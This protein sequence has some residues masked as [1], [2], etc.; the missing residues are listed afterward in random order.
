MKFPTSPAHYTSFDGGVSLSTLCRRPDRYAFFDEKNSGQRTISRGAGL[1]Y[2]A[3]SFS[4]SS[5]SIEHA[6]FNRLLSFSAEDA[7]LEVEAGVTLGQIEAFLSPRGFYLPVQP[8]HP[9]ISV[10]GCIAADVHGKNQFMDGTFSAHVK[11]LTLSHPRHG[12]LK[13]SRTEDDVVFKLTCGGYGLTGHI[14]SATL[15]L[16][17]IQA[18]FVRLSVSPIDRMESLPTM[19][20]DAAARSDLVYTWH[21]FTA[22]GESFG[23][24]V[25]TEGRF[26]SKEECENLT[27]SKGRRKDSDL[28]AHARGSWCAAFFNGTTTPLF[29]RIFGWAQRR[30]T[31]AHFQPLYDFLFPVHNKEVYF[32]LFGARGFLECQMI[33]P[34]DRYPEFAGRLRKRLNDER[35]PVTLASAKLFRGARELLRFSGEGI[36]F[37][38]NFPRSTRGIQFAEFLDEL[39]PS[40]N[41][42][43][44]IIKDS[45]LPRS[46]VEKTYPDC[47]QFR[48]RLRAFDSERLCRSELSERLGL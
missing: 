10:G 18:P 12:V 35:I 7:V 2:C 8:G 19:L 38:L 30:G 42:F 34:V 47:D 48:Q 36:C 3:A 29:N 31:H 15:A 46:V 24:G 1:S 27:A 43:P 6:E 4:Q 22:R 14:L 16:K 11:K 17:K 5:I 26:A 23:R 41:G 40:V 45:R 33:V 39:L 13:L 9:S 20:K 32:K 37:A 28:S 44:N 25:L 21:D